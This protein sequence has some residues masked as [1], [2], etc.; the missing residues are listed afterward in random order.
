MVSCGVPQRELAS[1]AYPVESEKLI[2]VTRQTAAVA[3]GQSVSEALLPPQP[4]LAQG[5][6]FGEL[7]SKCQR[8]NIFDGYMGNSN[9]TWII[10]ILRRLMEGTPLALA[11]AH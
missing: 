6:D 11:G 9:S 1:G 7:V 4:W 3:H 8:S 2:E 5:C 10:S